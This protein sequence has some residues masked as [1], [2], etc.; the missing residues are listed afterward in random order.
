M[1]CQR[2]KA[3][4]HFLPLH[5]QNP[6]FMRYSGLYTILLTLFVCFS[7]C[8]DETESAV[9]LHI[10]PD[11]LLKPAKSGEK[12]LYTITARSNEGVI[13]NLRL[14][15]YDPA[16]GLQTIWDSVFEKQQIRYTYQ[17]TVPQ[18]SDTTDVRLKFEAVNEFEYSASMT[19]FIKI[20]GGEM[21]L[22][23]LT[24]ITLYAAGSGQPDAFNIK[25]AQLIN[26][27]TSDADSLID[28]YCWQDE[29][30][31]PQT[32]SR[33]WRSHS[34]LKF[35]RFNSFN[36]ASA[37]QLN[38]ENAYHAGIQLNY[39]KDIKEEDIIIVGNDLHALGIIKVVYVFD[40]PGITQD[41]YI[42]N[43]KRTRY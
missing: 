32:L 36:Y 15:T 3:I 34:G 17:Y 10:Q 22:E 39:I 30:T 24:G 28:I 7:A 14:T 27:Q 25:S 35:A 29:D 2:K 5:L 4:Q 18:F 9:I 13:R 26:T 21:K 40:D 16:N 6:L 23:E 11:D 33:E 1:S 12:I 38:V 19:R 37:S 31:D 41:R 42:F 43:I 20:T 8:E